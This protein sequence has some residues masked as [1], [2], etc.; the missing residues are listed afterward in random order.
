MTY[1]LDHLGSLIGGALVYV[2][3]YYVG[4]YVE[5]NER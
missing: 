2:I 1:L 4:R 3:G 5:R